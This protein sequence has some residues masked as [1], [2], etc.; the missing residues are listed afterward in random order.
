MG[1]KT[2]ALR[3]DEEVYENL[4]KQLADY[5]DPDLNISFVIR[6]VL[7]D[8]NDAM[9]HLKKSS[10]GIMNNFVFW[11]SLFKHVDTLVQL[12]SLAKGE[13]IHER[14]QAEVDDKKAF[15]KNRK[16]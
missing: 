12:E 8:F 7:R 14:A 6:K 1:L 10:S 9:P 15:W 5:G 4:K 13:A 3:L 11:T 2:Y 16:K